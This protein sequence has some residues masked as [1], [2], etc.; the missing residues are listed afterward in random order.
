MLIIAGHLTITPGEREDYL[1][2]CHPIVARAR[3][4]DGCL[5][6][7]LTADVLD[8]DRIC[9]YERWSTDDALDRFRA[10]A[11]DDAPTSL[12]VDAEVARYRIATVEPA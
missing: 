12:I 5:D 1:R 10:A 7:S 2:S 4:A 11:G 3:T 6:F 9:V 8:P